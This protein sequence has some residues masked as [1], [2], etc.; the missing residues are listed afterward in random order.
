LYKDKLKTDC[1]SCHKKDDK[2]EGQE[3][4]KCES[5]HHEQSW[6][7]VEFDHRMSRYPL[8][9]NHILAECKK[10]HLTAR[11]KDTKSDC[12]SCHEK[13]DVHKHT[14]G[15]ACETCHNTRNWKDWDFDHDK[16]HFKLEGKHA[17]LKCADCHK[18]PA[19]GKVVQSA[20]CVSCHD[21]DDKH[22]G[23][24]GSL[25]ERCH[26]GTTWKTIKVGSES[27]LKK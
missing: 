19:T 7:K 3:G 16:T 20:N 22:D 26:I 24:Y 9:G 21:K 15:T 14:L 18:M 17:K 11:F 25:C 27:W 4:K 1:Y 6:K 10:C 2:H 23:A 12:W 13:Q 5:C 8:T